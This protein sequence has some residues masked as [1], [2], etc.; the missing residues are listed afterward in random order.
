MK[1]KI[2][3]MYSGD[4]WHKNIPFSKQS[5]ETRLSFEDWYERGVQYNIQFYRASIT[6]FD[7]K[8]GTFTKS[9]T[10]ES[11]KWI[12]ISKSIKPV[13]IYDKTIGKNDYITFE[14]KMKIFQKVP[15]LNH[16]LFRTITNNK[17]SQYMLL[18]EHMPQTLLANN[19]KELLS[20]LES[21]KGSRVVIK[22]LHGS[23]GFGIFIGKKTEAQKKRLTYPVIAQEF[24]TSTKGIPGFSQKDEVADL[25]LIYTNHTLVYALSRI[26]KKGSLF[27]NF[28][29]GASAVLVPKNKIPKDLLRMATNITKKLSAFS[30]ANY[31]LDFIFDDN[32]KPILVEMNTTPGFDL[33]RIVGTEQVKKLNLEFFVKTINEMTL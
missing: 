3:I 20:A 32:G 17:L 5:F 9:W 23:G 24:I 21:L 8:T 25:R 13:A 11:G 2:V 14:E 26:A 30:H 1:R 12:K 27:T 31:S 10:F 33:L 22:P 29:Q 19:K 18:G 28:H 15:I 7:Q 4:D 6:W 16:P